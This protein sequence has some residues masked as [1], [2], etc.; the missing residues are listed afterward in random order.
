VE[1]LDSTVGV[2]SVRVQGQEIVVH[3]RDTPPRVLRAKKS[4]LFAAARRN[5]ADR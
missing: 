1:Q 4:A 5:T 3:T 2:E